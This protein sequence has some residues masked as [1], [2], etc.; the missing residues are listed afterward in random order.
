[1]LFSWIYRDDTRTARIVPEHTFATY[2]PVP[3]HTIFRN[4]YQS[5]ELK[6]SKLTEFRGET[7][8]RCELF[9]CG[10]AA[11]LIVTQRLPIVG[12]GPNRGQV[13]HQSRNQSKG[14]ACFQKYYMGLHRSQNNKDSNSNH[15]KAVC[16]GYTCC[17]L[18]KYTFPAL[19]LLVASFHQHHTSNSQRFRLHLDS[20]WHQHATLVYIDCCPSR[21]RRSQV[22]TFRLFRTP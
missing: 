5:L 6:P 18:R 19:S 8:I 10:G 15:H 17:C 1:M 13:F 21:R 3:G 2:P 22:D 11:L 16:L 4:R 9:G 7:S 12:L 20:P 14:F